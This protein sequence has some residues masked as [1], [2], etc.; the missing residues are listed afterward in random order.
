[1]TDVTLAYSNNRRRRNNALMR[2]NA[3]MT[4]SNRDPLLAIGAKLGV[5]A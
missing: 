3:E 4:W 1:M 2:S 5:A